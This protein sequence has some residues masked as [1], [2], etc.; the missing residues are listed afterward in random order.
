MQQLYCYV[1]E[2]GQDT[3]GKFFLVAV[4]LTDQEKRE[5]VEEELAEIEE[6]SRKRKLKWNGANFERRLAYLDGIMRLGLLEGSLFYAVYEGTKEYVRLTTNAVV[7]A[8]GVGAEEEYRVTVV[9]DGL[10]EKDV[11]RVALGLRQRRV[12]Y[13][14]VRGMQDGASAF[15][16]L[17][18]VLAGFLRDYEEGET[19]TKDIVERL[20]ARGVLTKLEE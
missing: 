5:T 3:E 14:G 17:A 16:R 7:Q 9:I 15:L 19:Y 10:N 1:D 12:R 20:S 6:A 8:V 11:R 4:V 13:R 2:S 18:D